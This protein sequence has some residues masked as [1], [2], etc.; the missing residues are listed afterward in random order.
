VPRV[1]GRNHP[2][3]LVH[4][5]P[6]LESLIQRP[7]DRTDPRTDTCPAARLRSTPASH[8]STA[9]S[10]RLCRALNVAT[11]RPV[12]RRVASE[13]TS[14]LRSRS[15]WSDRRGVR[16]RDGPKKA[17]R[18][19]PGSVPPPTARAR[20]STLTEGRPLARGRTGGRL[21]RVSPPIANHP[22]CELP[23]RGCVLPNKVPTRAG[24]VVLPPTIR[25]LPRVRGSVPSAVRDGELEREL[26][27]AWRRLRL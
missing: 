12:L 25:H 8:R 6:E 19:T 17:S 11:F 9:G 7:V 20:L 3:R 1:L 4:G 18:D 26:L 14:N 2:A 22:S 5:Y 15:G 24:D 21:L 13:E 16:R 27:P 23:R 10:R